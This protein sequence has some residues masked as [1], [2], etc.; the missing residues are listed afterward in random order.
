MVYISNIPL[1]AEFLFILF[2]ENPLKAYLSLGDVKT[3]SLLESGPNRKSAIYVK[4][5]VSLISEN[6]GYDIFFQPLFNF[7]RIF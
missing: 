1:G 5:H 7:V 3:H 6:A 4:A 2:H